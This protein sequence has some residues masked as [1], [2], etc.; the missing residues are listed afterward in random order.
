MPAVALPDIAA[1]NKSRWETADPDATPDTVLFP[2]D[3]PQSM[4]KRRSPIALDSA[5]FD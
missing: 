5:A 2:A 1:P 3:L 4:G